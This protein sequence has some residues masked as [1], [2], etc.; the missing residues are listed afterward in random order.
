MSVEKINEKIVV[1]V[2]WMSFKMECWIIMFH[3]NF[4]YKTFFKQYARR[5]P[6]LQGEVIFYSHRDLHSVSKCVSDV[7]SMSR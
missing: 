5:F 4:M 1:K 7:K 2:N 3:A 6:L